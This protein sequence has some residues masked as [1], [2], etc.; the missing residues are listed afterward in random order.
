MGSPKPKNNVNMV[1]DNFYLLNNFIHQVM[2]VIFFSM[3]FHACNASFVVK[4]IYNKF[5]VNNCSLAIFLCEN[6]FG[7]VL[8]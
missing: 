1:W 5:S 3:K 8:Q 7:L 6:S 2:L 4:I